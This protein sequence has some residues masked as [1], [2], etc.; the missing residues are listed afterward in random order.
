M[1]AAARMYKEM[2]EEKCTKVKSLNLEIGELNREIGGLQSAL[3]HLQGE[4]Q[5]KLDVL[6]GKLKHE[7]ENEGA[8]SC[9]FYDISGIRIFP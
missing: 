8:T 3:A 4:L 6:N 1:T 7:R 5:D 9:R 2:Y